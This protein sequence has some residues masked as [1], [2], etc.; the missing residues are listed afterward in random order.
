M[1]GR[2]P[3]F[4]HKW[5]FMRFWVWFKGCT[6]GVLW[7]YSLIF[8]ICYDFW[9]LFSSLTR[10]MYGIPYPY[11][12]VVLDQGELGLSKQYSLVKWANVGGSRTQPSFCLFFFWSR[13]T[14]NLKL[15]FYTWDLSR[16]TN[17]LQIHRHCSSP[18]NA[19]KPLRRYIIWVIV[20][21]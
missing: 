20:K 4:L 3:F 21:Y 5:E 9:I 14:G 17:L 1:E 13:N 19:L 8:I 12:E 10:F 11:S 6:Q 16:N 15:K 18:C 2:F 7:W